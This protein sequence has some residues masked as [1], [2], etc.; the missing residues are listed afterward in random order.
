MQSI[1]QSEHSAHGSRLGNEIKLWNASPLG[2]HFCSLSLPSL[3]I[4]LFF[5]FFTM[6]QRPHVQPTTS[7]YRQLRL[8]VQSADF[9]NNVKFTS[10][11]RRRK[12]NY[13]RYERNS[14]RR[15]RQR[16]CN[17]WFRGARS[18]ICRATSSLFVANGIISSYCS[19]RA[20]P[21]GTLHIFAS[22]RDRFAELSVAR[23]MRRPIK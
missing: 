20:L 4:Y 5:F 3:T 7:A 9:N 21:R 8:T 2:G 22:D 15:A 16:V 19:A 13:A 11:G 23:T 17:V 10:P 18:I 1:K 12:T 6:V 14:R